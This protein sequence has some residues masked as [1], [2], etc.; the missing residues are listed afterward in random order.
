MMR[1]FGRFELHDKLGSGAMGSVF[2]GFQKAL[3]RRCVLKIIHE[4]LAEHR[5][6]VERFQAE[7]LGAARLNHPNVVQVIDF[8]EHEG[9]YYIAMEFAEGLDLKRW[10]EAHGQPPLEIAFLL[11]RE[12]CAGLE[13]AHGRKV[14]HR[15]IK[16]ANLIFT[17]EGMLKISDFGLARREDLPIGITMDG[18]VLGAPA[19]MSPEQAA[20]RKVDAR[21]DIF[22]AGVVGFQ[23]LGG[24]LPFEGDSPSSVMESIRTKEPPDLKGLNPLVPE[25]MVRIIDRMLKKDLSL[26]YQSIATVRGALDGVLEQAGLGL[27]RGKDLL[28]EY[29]QDPAGVAGVL[30]ARRIAGCLERGLALDAEGDSQ[31]EESLLEFRRVLFLEPGHKVAAE[32]AKRLERSLAR[33]EAERARR[34]VQA[35]QEAEKTQ[36]LP[37]APVPPPAAPPPDVSRSAPVQ[38]AAPPQSPVVPPVEPPRAPASPA[39][40]TKVVLSG[41]EGIPQPAARVPVPARRPATPP[42][43]V[44][45]PVSKLPRSG[46]A[47]TPR[48]RSI[49]LLS[50]AAGGLVVAIVGLA[51][52]WSSIRKHR[53]E[54]PPPP[55]SRQ[56]LVTADTTATMRLDVQPRDAE[57]LL[58]NLPRRPV[59]AGTFAF[60]G[61][62]EGPH[63]VRVAKPG[64][65]AWERE[66]P[67]EAGRET[68]LAVKLVA[69][70][71]DTGRAT[72][73]VE[74]RP[75]ATFFV[76]GR[77]LAEN[78][79][80]FKGSFRAGRHV[81]RVENPRFPAGAKTQTVQ[82]KTGQ[83]RKVTFSFEATGFGYIRVPKA[84]GPC[85]WATVLIDGEAK[86]YTPYFSRVATGKHRVELKTGNCGPDPAFRLVQV[87]GGDTSVAVFI[88]KKK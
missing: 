17:T 77:K 21:S 81:I 22:S 70:P 63:R 62:T 42:R 34:E 82:L 80:T 68:T 53:E 40:S 60:R 31:V 8:G 1:D 2:L 47:P 69:V 12:L 33:I 29:A 72:L 27:F 54:P 52:V 75:Y 74:A 86:G 37:Q 23:L 49:R 3:D 64:Y 44:P 35:L 73:V 55:V 39:P 57:V 61:L 5:E 26:R 28:R 20:G 51:I 9:R 71:A 79:V 56:P 13:H 18:A 32:H 66:F 45:T 30:R 6:F 24:G 67:L 25:S 36:I 14:I 87:A 10:M 59:V 4:H 43:P 19:Y 76:D 15:D 78:R 48:G 84:K 41:D 11:L 85:E 46:R 58:D 7:A 88:L 65:R 16:P 38:L 50:I 83:H